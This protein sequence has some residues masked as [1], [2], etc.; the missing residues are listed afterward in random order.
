MGQKPTP[1]F[2]TVQ[3][4]NRE[5]R[6]QRRKFSRILLLAI[7]AVVAL[8]LLSTL[9]LTVCSIADHLLPDAPQQN[10][11]TPPTENGDTSNPTSTVLY[12]RI[13]QPDYAVHKGSLLIVNS[14]H[15][16]E[17][18]TTNSGLKN[19][20]DN[21]EKYDGVSNT[22]QLLNNT[23]QLHTDALDA[24]NA[25]ML[26][27][28]AET[29]DGSIRITGAYRTAQEQA[30]GYEAGTYDLPAGYSD[31]HTGL[32]IA[33]RPQVAGEY[34]PE[35]HWIYQNCHK[36]GF[37]V[38]YPESKSDITQVSGYDYCFR[39]VGIEH[40]TYITENNLCLEE[41]TALLATRYQKEN[42][43]SIV[44]ESGKRYEVYYVAATGDVTTLEVP[45][46]RQYTISGDNIN[47]FIVSVH[48]DEPKAE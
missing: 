10:Q 36:Y 27:Y 46:N 48:L 15:I 9:I 5:A 14:Q 44:T 8:L 37:I 22:Y 19:I 47:G 43:L 28:Y 35:S 32:C 29:Q 24:L 38:R 39:Y 17:F 2:N 33:L 13:T 4:S 3:K 6:K 41:Y 7:F 1:S 42:P 31:H 40:A 30:S 25:M 20:Y 45:K 18:P 12:E 23:I 34:L 11:E 16:Y 21:R 26:D